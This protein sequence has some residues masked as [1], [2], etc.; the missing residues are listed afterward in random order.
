MGSTPKPYEELSL[1][2]LRIP[3]TDDKGR[4]VAA[5]AKGTIVHVPQLPPKQEPGYIVEIVL[6][7]AQGVHDDSHLIDVCHSEIEKI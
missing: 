6:F 4:P 3:K 5:G 1:V 7:N 2:R